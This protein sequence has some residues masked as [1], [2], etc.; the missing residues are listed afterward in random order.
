MDIVWN[1]GNVCVK[2]TKEYKY[3]GIAP[4]DIGRERIMDEKLSGAC[5]W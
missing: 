3:L 4:N 2:R 1:L 5:Q